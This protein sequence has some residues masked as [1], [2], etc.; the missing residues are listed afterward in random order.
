MS[1]VCFQVD[2]INAKCLMTKT[3]ISAVIS[4]VVGAAEVF[5]EC[6][7]YALCHMLHFSQKH[8]P[9][10]ICICMPADDAANEG[11]LMLLAVTFCC[12]DLSTQFY[13]CSNRTCSICGS[14]FHVLAH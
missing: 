4:D 10:T 1:N 13:S 12:L 9:V 11:I 14:R 6:P 3:L 7:L 8:H 5:R 2:G